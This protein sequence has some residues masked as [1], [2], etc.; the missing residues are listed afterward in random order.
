MTEETRDLTLEVLETGSNMYQ[1]MAELYPICRSITGNG[2]RESLRIIQK[3]IPLELHEVPTGTPV[4]DWNVPKEWNIRDAYVKGPNGDKIID[5]QRSSLNVVNYSVPVRAKMPLAK[6]KEHLHSLPDHPD[7]VPYRTSYY[8]E[9]WGFCLSQRALESLEEGEYEAV[10]DSSLEEGNLTYGE[11]YLK[12]ATQDE[13]LISSHSCHPSLCN[14]NLSGMVLATFLARYLQT[15]K[16]RYSY[17]FIFAPGTIGAITWLAQNE[18][19]TSRIKHGL[20]AACV[21]DEGKFHYKKSRRGDAEIDAAVVHALKHSGEDYVVSEFTPYDYDER[22]YCSPGFN[23]PVGSLTR[24]PHDCYKENHTSAD[25][26]DLVSPEQLAGSFQVYSRVLRILEQNK[27]YLNTNPMCEPRLGK[28]GLYGA[29]GGK[30]D[31][32]TYELALQWTLNYSDGQHSL[33]EI[34][35]KSGFRFEVIKEAA[36]KLVEHNLLVEAGA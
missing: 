30:R 13:I 18:S 4:F 34:A 29:V 31:A 35:N 22:Q 28:R 16:L 9:T 8:K 11:F 2:L 12:G 6:L 33:L 32:N 1:L 21:G 36:F 15:C 10:I 14:D 19:R 5:F 23:L 24:T 17:R 27:K 3:H 20:V 26:M 25:N 7:W